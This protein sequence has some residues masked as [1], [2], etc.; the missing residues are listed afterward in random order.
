VAISLIKT[1]EGVVD[2]GNK[3]F[4]FNFFLILIEQV[5]I[6]KICKRTIP[7]EKGDS[8]SSIFHS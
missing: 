1:G 8:K 6:L 5:Q 2:G 7:S 4:A 3:N